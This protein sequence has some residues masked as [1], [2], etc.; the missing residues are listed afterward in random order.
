MGV[1]LTWA[2]VIMIN[3]GIL[4]IPTDI[5]CISTSPSKEK[6]ALVEIAQET[7]KVRGWFGYESDTSNT[8]IAVQELAKL[9][10]LIL[11]L[12]N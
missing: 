5:S 12:C 3:I 6:R 9:D 2:S 10:Y 4:N 8:L 11:A 7:C 1:Y